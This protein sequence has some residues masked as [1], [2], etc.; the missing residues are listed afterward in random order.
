MLLLSDLPSAFNLPSYLLPYSLLFPLPPF[1]VAPFLFVFHF[2]L[3]S[4]FHSFRRLV[5]PSI[6]HS[7]TSCLFILS[8]PPLLSFPSLLSSLPLSFYFSSFVVCLVFYLTHLL[9][10][11]IPFSP[12]FSLPFFSLFSL[13]TL[14]FVYLLFFVPPLPHLSVVSF[15]YHPL[16]SSFSPPLTSSLPSSIF[17]QHPTPVFLSPFILP[18]LPHSLTHHTKSFRRKFLL[19]RA[20]QWRRQPLE[21]P[22]INSRVL[23]L[24]PGAEGGPSSLEF[25]VIDSAVAI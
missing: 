24:G 16:L 23:T 6:F 12:C 25:G 20:G 11:I 10:F 13:L 14:T 1:P 19:F 9:P 5:S 7:I 22:W 15:H 21:A 3:I 4:L 8:S 18:P 17:P 2:C